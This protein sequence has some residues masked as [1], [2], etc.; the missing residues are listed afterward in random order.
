MN[1]LSSNQ[2]QFYTYIRNYISKYI[3]HFFALILCS[4][5]QVSYYSGIDG[6]A[7]ERNRET[8]DIFL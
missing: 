3:I 1:L 7:P 4:V 5:L 8:D 6:R 2:F